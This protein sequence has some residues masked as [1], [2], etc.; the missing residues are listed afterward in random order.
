[1]KTQN[2]TSR[3]GDKRNVVANGHNL[4]TITGKA[5]YWRVGMGEDNREIAYFDPE[6]GPFFSVG[7][8]YG[9]GVIQ[10]IAVEQDN[11]KGSFKILVEV[12]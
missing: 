4:Y 9:F 11:A 1:M 3:Y 5:H 10:S 12:A 6:G 2:L 8:D 7:S